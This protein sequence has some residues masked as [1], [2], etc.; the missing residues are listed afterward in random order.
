MSL[1]FVLGKSG[2][3]KSF[4]MYKKYAD[5]A[6]SNTGRQYLVIVPEQFTL[7]TQKNMV[8]SSKGNVILNLDVLS[9]E[10]LSHRIF[11][12]L[13]MSDIAVLKETGKSFL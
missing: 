7:Q 8:S 2:S 12:E 10:R 11:D 1:Q 9:F 6:K 5:M 4:G 3:G 13:G